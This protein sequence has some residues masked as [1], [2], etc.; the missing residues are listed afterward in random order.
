M[1]RL[2][3][4]NRDWC[5]WGDWRMETAVIHEFLFSFPQVIHTVFPLKW[6]SIIGKK[7]SLRFILQ[8][9]NLKHFHTCYIFQ[10]VRLA[11]TRL[12]TVRVH[13]PHH[14]WSVMFPWLPA[15]KK[16]AQGITFPWLQSPDRNNKRREISVQRRHTN[17]MGSSWFWMLH[18]YVVCIYHSQQTGQFESSGC[19]GKT[20]GLS[21]WC[22][23]SSSDTATTRN[24][25]QFSHKC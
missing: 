19:V 10:L 8:S 21:S 6:I 23:T 14:W 20:A 15:R 12:F 3:K 25:M 7:K 16:G 22:G 9:S 13:V 11:V 18:F 5:G 1:F 24:T 4:K 2:T 17:C